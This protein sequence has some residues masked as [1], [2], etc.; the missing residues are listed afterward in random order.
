MRKFSA[1]FLVL[2]ICGCQQKQSESVPTTDQLMADGQ[3][4]KA[5]QGKCDTGEYSQLPAA[6]KDNM[7]F[8]T[9]EAARSLAVKKMN[10]L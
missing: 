9:R 5:W 3:L 7:C 1:L 10:G 2:A 6:E 8:T 4:L